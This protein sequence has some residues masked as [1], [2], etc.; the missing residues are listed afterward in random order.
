MRVIKKSTSCKLHQ[1]ETELDE[2]TLKSVEVFYK[3][4]AVAEV[5][6]D[7]DESGA[8]DILDVILINKVILGKDTITEQG[9]ANAD[10][11]MNEVPDSVDSLNVMKM[12]V[13]LLKAEECPINVK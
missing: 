6:G 7:A 1:G 8:V 2:I 5:W 4:K 11:N 9:L 10:L 13:G 3:E 12:I